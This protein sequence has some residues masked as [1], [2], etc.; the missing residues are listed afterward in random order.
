MAMKSNGTLHSLQALRAIAAW[1]VI[2]D[3]ALLELSHNA[4]ADPMTH[5]AWT[6][7]STGVYI[8]FVISGFI[9]VHISWADF[10]RWPNAVNFLRRRIM[11]IVPLYWLST[12]V[13]LAYHRVSA[14]HGA[15]A[16]W[17]DLM[18]S[19]SFIPYRDDDGSWNP[20]L[21]Q[22]WT[23]EY[24]MMFYILFAFGLCLRRQI[25][26][27]VLAAS[28][29]MFVAAGPLLTDERLT[30]LASSI[31]LWFVL[32][33]ML[34]VTWRW[35][36]WQEPAWLA[37]LAKPFE[38]FGNASYSTY[39]CH[40]FV[41]TM[42]LRIWTGVAGPPSILIVAASLVAATAVGWTIHL[43]VERPLLRL[44]I[45]FREPRREMATS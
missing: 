23:L 8:F 10:G 39:L 26:L 4:V 28:L 19:F 17:S 16:G 12:I 3:H 15:H 25:A 42:L 6:L 2:I 32:G 34:A 35:R 33:M 37:R 30:Y 36:G 27:P 29:C 7:G 20:I 45:N 44:L 13:A 14:T 31:L 38:P 11:R 40:G 43:T 5:L 24:E 1:L 22:G 21:P 18:C 9:M 41:L